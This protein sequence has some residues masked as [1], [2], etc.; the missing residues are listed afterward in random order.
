MDALKGRASCQQES[1]DA[2]L[3]IAIGISNMKRYGKKERGFQAAIMIQ[4]K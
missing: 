2:T 1:K 3:L 4:L